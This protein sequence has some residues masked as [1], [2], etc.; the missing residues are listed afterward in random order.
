MLKF[1]EEQR[2]VSMSRTESREQVDL[3]GSSP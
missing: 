1:C 3:Q 2:A